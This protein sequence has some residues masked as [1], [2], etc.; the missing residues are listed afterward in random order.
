MPQGTLIMTK[1]LMGKLVLV[2]LPTETAVRLIRNADDNLLDSIRAAV[3]DIQ[4]LNV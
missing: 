4:L 3:Q 1:E 2:V